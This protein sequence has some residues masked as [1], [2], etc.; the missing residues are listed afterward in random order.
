MSAIVSATPAA[1]PDAPP[2]FMPF[3]AIG[4]CCWRWEAA[5]NNGSRITRYEIQWRPVSNPAQDWS[6]WAEVSGGA[7]RATRR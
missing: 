6:S 2:H 7:V 4:R 5:A 1:V 3:Q